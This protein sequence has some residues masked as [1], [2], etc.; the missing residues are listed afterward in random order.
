MIDRSFLEKVQEMA[1]T[2][3]I[4]VDERPYST[5]ELH[6]VLDPQ[7]K[8]LTVR[9]LSAI[10][11]YLKSNVDALSVGDLVLHIANQEK[12]FLYDS[13]REPWEKRDCYLEACPS[14]RK[15]QFGQYYQSENF[16]IGLQTSFVQDE[17]TAAILKIVG[18]LSHEAVTNFSD[19][20]VTQKITAKVGITRV[21]DLPVPSPVELRP[22]RTFLEVEQPKSKFI[23]RIQGKE[24]VPPT[25]ALFEADGGQWELKAIQNISKWLRAEVPEEVTILA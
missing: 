1:E 19:D 2:K 11:D 7:P 17:S 22:Y 24:G 9:T 4:T 21:M 20:G 6:P 12:V 15:F 10:R 18:N 23:L 16:I 5:K 13:L 14:L 25:C 3:I 8:A